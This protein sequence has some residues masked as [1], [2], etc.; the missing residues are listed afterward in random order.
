[1][2]PPP[3]SF[4]AI[5]PNTE[6]SPTP[7]TSAPSG[8]AA[9]QVNAA[10]T[11][12]TSP[13]A[14]PYPCAM[15]TITFHPSPGSLVKRNET[16]LPRSPMRHPPPLRAMA[17]APRHR[18]APAPRNDIKTRLDSTHH[19]VQQPHSTSNDPRRDCGTRPGGLANRRLA[20][21]HQTEPRRPRHPDTP[22][23][24]RQQDRTARSTPMNA[25]FLLGI[26]TGLL[27]GMIITMIACTIAERR[28]HCDE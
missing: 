6:S 24:S 3:G 10:T 15:R 19:S 16:P 26:S 13:S 27:L 2:S 17:T 12:A 22:K 14:Q 5:E 11:Q 23:H 7:F 9:H 8:T 1:M 21:R 20:T 28:A 4:T 18:Q 25:A